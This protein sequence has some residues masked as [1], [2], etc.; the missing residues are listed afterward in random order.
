MRILILLAVFAF[1]LPAMAQ[2][3]FPVQIDA[4]AVF[5]EQ[6]KKEIRFSG[7][8]GVSHKGLV[9]K[10]EELA[11]SYEEQID[12]ID[13]VV[14][15]GGV[16][17]SKDAEKVTGDRATYNIAE[18]ILLLEGNVTYLRDGSLLKGEKLEYNVATGKAQLMGEEVNRVRAEFSSGVIRGQK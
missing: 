16:S 1:S 6:D 11:A 12:D 8:V 3:L 13:K 15:K 17:V 14:A 4:D 7:N 5:F 2:Q 9:L 10:A 18:Q